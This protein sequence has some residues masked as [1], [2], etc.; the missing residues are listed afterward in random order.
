MSV[1][2]SLMMIKP[3]SVGRGDAPEILS[4]I[5]DNVPVA[6]RG[7]RSWNICDT[8]WFA[9]CRD[10]GPFLSDLVYEVEKIHAIRQVPTWI[11]LFAHLDR[12]TDPTEALIDYCGSDDRTL[13]QPRH[14]RHKYSGFTNY[15]GPTAHASDTVVHIASPKR[16]SFEAAVLFS[17]FDESKI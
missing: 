9:L 8:T 1:P 12:E 11:C 14:L 15:V 6:L 13:W 3:L 10:K 16:V 4:K 17:Q 2:Y 7:F 5:L